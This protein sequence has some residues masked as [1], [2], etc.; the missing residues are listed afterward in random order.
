[1]TQVVIDD[2]IPDNSFLRFRSQYVKYLVYKHT[3]PS[4]KSYIGQ[5]KNYNKRCRYHQS[6]KECIAF[7]LAI[8]KYGWDNFTH[9]ILKDNLTIEEANYW[10]EFYIKYY[11]SLFPHGYNIE[12][13]GRNSSL[14]EST[15]EKLSLIMKGRTPKN[16]GIPH[17]DTSKQKMSLAAKGRVPWN[18]GKKLSEDHK[19]KLSISKCNKK[20]SAETIEKRRQKLIGH[21]MTEENKAKL[22]ASSKGRIIS[23]ETRMKMSLAQKKRFSKEKENDPDSYRRYNS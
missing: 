8:Q 11:Q 7:Y 4:G 5:T 2:I 12:A 18:K 9:E 16:K 17:K 13:G 10:E 1:M 14:A 15:K 6:Y 19:K 3:S 23:E 22:I 20:Q 21:K